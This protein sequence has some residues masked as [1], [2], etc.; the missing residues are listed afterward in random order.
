MPKGNT[1]SISDFLPLIA[2]I[3]IIYFFWQR[4]QSAPLATNNPSL[5]KCKDCGQSVSK[6][7]NACPHCGAKQSKTSW[8]TWAVAAFMLLV[9]F[10]IIGGVSHTIPTPAIPTRAPIPTAAT[11]T[12]PTPPVS[13][14]AVQDTAQAKPDY[15]WEYLFNRDAVTENGFK[16]ATVTSSNSF[17]LNF[18]YQGGTTG[19][20]TI[21]N[22]P[23]HGNDIIFSI[24]KGQL[25]CNGYEGCDVIVSFDGRKPLTI[26]AN[27]SSDN[28]STTLFLKGYNRFIK[29]IEKSNTMKVEVTFFQNGT[30]VFEF[31]VFNFKPSEL[32]IEKSK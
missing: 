22:H 12:T 10:N 11:T 2:L 13:S 23:R 32:K 26:H 5:T 7:A 9:M 1:M 15:P 14:T 21:R 31:I 6:N 28:S 24:N 18:P 29:E 27:T 8:L 19:S 30:R 17:D 4:N 20:V 25:L 3:G 16:T